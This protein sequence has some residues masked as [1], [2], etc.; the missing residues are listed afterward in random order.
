MYFRTRLNRIFIALIA[1]GMLT[2]WSCSSTPKKEASNEKPNVLLIFCDQLNKKVMGFE[3]HPDVITPNLDQLAGESVIFDRAYCSQGI[4]VPS[5][6]SL[7]TGLS[8]R[9]MGFINNGGHTPVMDDVVSMATI[10]RQNGYRTYAFGKRHLRDSIDA[11]WDVK[12]DHSYRTDDDDNYVSWIVRNGYEKELAQD[13]AAEFGRGPKGTSESDT[14]IPTAD[15]GTRISSLPEDYT[16]E[17]YT[18][19]ETIEMIKKH[20]NSDSSF[21]CWAS[22]YRPHQPYNPLPK[23]MAMYDVTKWGEGTKYGSAIRKPAS[24]YEPTENLPPQLQQQRNGGNKVWN[25]DKAFGDEQ[26]WRNYIGGYYALVTEIDHHVGEILKAL[27]EAN[28]DNETIVIF[29]SDHGDFVGN[30]GMV[31]KCAFGQNVYEDILN[32]PLIIRVPGN[33]NKGKHVAELVMNTDILPT[34]IELLDL[35]VPELKYP[36]QGES[37]SEVVLDDG[38]LDREYVVSESW[39]QAAVITK[40]YTL[41]IMLDPTPA[42]P[43]LDYRDF[44]DMFFDRTKD[45]LEVDNRI[46]DPGYKDQIAMLRGY[47]DEFVENTP[48]DGK[49][50][51]IRQMTNQ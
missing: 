34:L 29:T 21:F 13:W 19:K 2:G 41:G 10:F 18:A 26:L 32:I 45:P 49:D 40:D 23:Y 43:E 27:E 42:H 25:M 12:K 11:G 30:H 48:S 15:L 31:E 9:T 47:Y 8:V 51:L 44:G 17:A 24:L 33:Q 14:R 1:A 3:G 50:A 28:L 4:C 16:M 38:T 6:S 7:M 22:F 5:R 20:A 37:L 35:Q 46:N 36:I 39:S